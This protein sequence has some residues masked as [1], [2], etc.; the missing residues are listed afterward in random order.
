MFCGSGGYLY[1]YF[2]VYE[3]VASLSEEEL[4]F[5]MEKSLNVSDPLKQQMPDHEINIFFNL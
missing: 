5:Y 2:R 3:F 1:L 4:A